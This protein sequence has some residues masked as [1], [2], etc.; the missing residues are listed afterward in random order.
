MKGRW[1]TIGLAALA[2]LPLLYVVVYLLLV[3][4]MPNVSFT[5]KGPWRRPAE[6]RFGGSVSERFFRPVHVIDRQLRPNVWAI[7]NVQDPTDPSF[8]KSLR[9]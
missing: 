5:G 6:Y 2:M 1:L 3:T 7:P 4:R 9:P 8:L